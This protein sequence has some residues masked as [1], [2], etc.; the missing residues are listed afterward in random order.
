MN[1]QLPVWLLDIDGVVNALARGPVHDSWPPESWVQCVIRADMPRNGPMVLPIFA[2]QPVLDFI[3]RAHHSGRVEVRWHSTWR[4]AAVTEL[5]PAL[6][7]P[8][9]IPISRP[10]ASV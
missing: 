8:T 5:A 10:M 4:T 3:T 2:A 1:E 7:L 9:T 6:G